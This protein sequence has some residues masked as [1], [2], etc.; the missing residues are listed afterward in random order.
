L[1]T[2]LPVEVVAQLDEVEINGNYGDFVMNPESIDIISLL[3]TINTKMKII[4]STN[5]GARD[6][7]FW[8]QLAKLDTQVCFCIDGLED[9]HHLYR[10]DTT[11]QQVI[12]NAK[13]YIDAGGQALWRMTEFDH[14]RHQIDEAQQ[15][16]KKLN[17]AYFS[18]RPTGRNTGPV[19]DRQGQQVFVLGNTNYNMP[20]TIDDASIENIFWPSKL[21][22]HLSDAPK[23][24]M[25]E[26]K[27]NK[28]IFISSEG[29]VKPCCY[30]ALDNTL[31][32]FYSGIKE[33]DHFESIE[34]SVALFKNINETFDTD[35][36]LVACQQFCTK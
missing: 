14:N 22:T 21:K 3:R 24:I 13:I 8:Q 36:Q 23:N 16:S 19:Y 20:D 11:Y 7:N 10:Q 32:Y 29:I 27:E 6:R 26:A 4:V 28:S 2:I 18:L 25:C 31:P 9:T 5:G 1:Q 30:L 33:L 12:K 15:R 35:K 17:F 34:K